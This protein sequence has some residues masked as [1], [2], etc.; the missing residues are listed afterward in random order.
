VLDPDA[1]RAA[2]LDDHGPTVEAVLACADDVADARDPPI[3]DGPG[4][5]DALEAALGGAG[6]LG[7][8]PAVLAT[9][10][11]A[12]GGTL[13]ARPVA[14]PPYVAVTSRGPVLRA[15]LDGG[16]LVVTVRAFAVERDPLRYVR[17]PTDP[18]AAVETAVR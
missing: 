18:A 9:A 10:V 4:L 1:A 8:L 3:T 2:I 15:T 16:R 13:S 14:A 11:D 5:A 6:V 7:T 17:G 12:A